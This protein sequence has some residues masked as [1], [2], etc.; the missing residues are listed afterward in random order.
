[1]IKYDVNKK[2]YEHISEFT[3]R[4]G[5]MKL[6]PYV[7]VKD[8]NTGESHVMRKNDFLLNG[9]PTEEV[10]EVATEEAVETAP[11]TVEIDET[12]ETP[13]DG[14][15][16]PD[17][18]GEQEEVTEYVAVHTRT[19]EEVTISGQ[20]ELNTFIE[21]HKLDTDAVEAMLEGKQNTHKKWRVTKK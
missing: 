2:P 8:W 19:K 10:A 9:L 6:V 1:M 13:E 16:E 5:N 20:D 14:V 17:T 11:E 21:K 15:I 4:E 7:R 3:V 18:T 12:P